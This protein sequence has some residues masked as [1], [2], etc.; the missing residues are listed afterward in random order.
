MLQEL[1]PSPALLIEQPGAVTE[2]T[3]TADAVIA[4][5]PGAGIVHFTCHAASHPSDPSRSQI[6]LHD[7]QENPFTV[8]SLAPVRLER[9]QLAFLSACETALNAVA[10]LSDESIHLTSAFHLA[11]YPHVIGTLW[12]VYDRFAVTVAS[13]FYTRLRN[14]PRPFAMD[15]AARALHHTV[16]DLRDRRRLAGRPSLWAAYTHTGA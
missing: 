9:G 13:G 15:A 14:E 3:P 2:R 6:L 7:H 10:E 4:R 8:A 12:P 11:G 5:L 16:L 1:L